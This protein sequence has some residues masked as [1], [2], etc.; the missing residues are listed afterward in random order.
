[1]IIVK[2]LALALS[3]SCLVA[4]LPS[5][6]G[7]IYLDPSSS[8]KER[9]EDLLKRMTWE[10]KIGQMG[11]V[12]R[13]LSAGLAFN[14]TS[15]DQVRALQ[16]GILGYGAQLNQARD[17]LPLANKYRAEQMNSSRLGIPYITVTDSVNSIYLAGG[18]MFPATL[19]MGSSFN[20][21]LYGQVVTAL[22]DENM[23]L[24]THWVLSPCLDV[25]KEPRGGRVG[26]MYGE[27]PY[28]VGEF[29]AQYVRTMQQRD[30]NG[31]IKVATTVKHFV[32]GL[33]SGG[34]NMASMFGGMNHVFNDLVP[35][36]IRAFQ[37]DPMSIMVSYATV[38]RVPMSVN[39][40]ML[41]DILRGSLGY[42][43]LI[44]SD[45]LA[46]L[47]LLTS[48]V[49]D[50]YPDSAL[51]ALHAGLQLELSP[52]Q[53]A[54]FP[55]LAQSGNN[56]AAV[57]LVDTAVRQMLE[58]KFAT[59][60]FDLVLPTQENLKK[61][62]RS[63]IH[64][65]INRNMSRESIVLLKNGG[66]LPVA[67]KAGTK[68]AV[69][70]PFAN[71]IN[72]G[73][74]APNNSSDSSRGNSLFASLRSEFGTDNVRYVQGVDITDTSDNSGI[75]DAVA[76]AA[77]ADLAVIMLGSL[78]VTLDDPLWRRRTDGEFFA[79]ADLGFPGLQQQ[80]LDAVLDAGV[81]TIVVLSGGQSFVLTNSTLRSN[82]ILHSFLGGEYTGDA[83]VDIIVGRV[84]PS[85]KLPITMPQ[86][87]G[88]V[89][90]NYDYL[91]MDNLG[92]PGH[93][94]SNFPISDWQLPILTR[95]PPMKFGFGLSYTTFNISAPILSV[96]GDGIV[97]IS[98]DVLN[99]GKYAGKEVVQVYFRQQSSSSIELPVK[100]LI[101]FLKIQLDP[102]QHET[103]VF[104][105]PHS[106][107]GYFK[108]NK[109]TV[110]A[111]NF[112]IY[113]GSSS[114]DED[115]KSANVILGM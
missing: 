16:N 60:M 93:F 6:N 68:I 63:A 23:A 95:D 80:L 84:N 110:D 85:G 107:M 49:A 62:L 54:M 5:S 90:I 96:T 115:M 3:T 92:G 39:K 26:E 11:G 31:Y 33:N 88:A 79:H 67:S 105:I 111:G 109:W 12:R 21:P 73:S 35:P 28:M 46:I 47:Y 58:I 83:L 52:S 34:V 99:T 15:Y 14:R 76:V 98:V 48:M 103:V 30:S 56:S 77:E 65:E 100:R 108:D 29:G 22:R 86:A 19:S 44:M 70:G 64:L 10:E 50:S 91:P 94:G 42:K 74:Y 7:A 27:D 82:A 45:A 66:V 25:A 2:I 17:V 9:A 104:T 101:R 114:R 51:K 71:I 75:K 32:Y 40:Y 1:M 97:Q 57:K 41:Q 4:T 43:G 8:A 89:P 113:V 61:T 102:S 18:T 38:D 24:G 69:L 59:G 81:P 13:L 55:Y 112:T 37:E 36:Y 78:S 53:P 20:I 87:S 106:E 72:A